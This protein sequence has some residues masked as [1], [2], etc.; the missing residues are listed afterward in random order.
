M[1]WCVVRV[2]CVNDDFINYKLCDDFIN[3]KLCKLKFVFS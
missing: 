1:N 3:Y 2:N